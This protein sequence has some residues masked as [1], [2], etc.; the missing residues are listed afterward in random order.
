M[1]GR[2]R[3]IVLVKQPP[4]ILLDVQGV[5]YELE[6]PMTTFYKTPE[7][8]AEMQLFTHL[9][10]REDAHLLFGFAS[11]GERRLFRALLK[12]NG[13]GARTA[14][15]ILSGMEVEMLVQC[16]QGADVQRLVRLP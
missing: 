13:V 2:L 4:H 12:V 10:V 9:A 3:G 5:G 6:A 1:I 7:V 16:I 8:G 15:T 11:E 14:L